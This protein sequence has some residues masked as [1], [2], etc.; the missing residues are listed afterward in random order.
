MYREAAESADVVRR[1][2]TANAPAAGR[3]AAQLRQSPPRAV[4]TCAR[5][6]RSK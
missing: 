4:V 2:L 5:G 6:S 3:L 1:Q